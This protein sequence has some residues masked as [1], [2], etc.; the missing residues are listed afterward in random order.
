VLPPSVLVCWY[1]PLAG[2]VTDLPLT[3]TVVDDE[4][5][6]E[7][8]DV[9]LFVLFVIEG[10]DSVVVVC[11]SETGACWLLSTG[12]SLGLEA[13]SLEPEASNAANVA[14]HN[15]T[16]SNAADRLYSLFREFTRRGE[17]LPPLWLE[18]WTSF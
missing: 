4:E 5:E 6:S 7:L 8:T 15:K 1:D 14:E 3:V 16:A 10:E 17:V 2:T 13:C 9:L 11:E 18:V 12:L